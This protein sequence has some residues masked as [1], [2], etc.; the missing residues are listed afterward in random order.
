MKINDCRQG[1]VNMQPAEIGTRIRKFRER[2]ALST[3]QLAQRSGLDTEFIHAMEDA[4]VTPS[5][6]T[7]PLP[8]R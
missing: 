5:L 4:D 2:Q 7:L 6:G 8:G 1:G 3:Q